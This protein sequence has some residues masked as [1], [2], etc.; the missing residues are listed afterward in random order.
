MAQVSFDPKIVDGCRELAGRIADDVQKLIDSHT[1]VGVERTTARALGVEGVDD[2]GTPLVNTL[3]DRLHEHKVLGH[4]VSFFIG[5]EM[6]RGAENA[7]I[8]A[9]RLAYGGHAISLDGQETD[10]QIAAVLHNATQEGLLRI[11]RARDDRDER[12]RK[13]GMA[14]TPWKYV[15]VAT[16]NIYD[17]AIQAKS[18]SFGGADV[19]AVIRATAQSLLDY[20]PDGP[21]TEGYGGTYATQ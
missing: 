8:A 17:D 16:G 11:D 13:Y 15:I 10:A 18:A 20:V 3:V 4:G 7:Q 6:L 12:R 19:V 5:R 1:T 9:E 14:E 2:Q 21:T